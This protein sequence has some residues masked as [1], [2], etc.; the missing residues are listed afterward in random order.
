TDQCG[1]SL[2]ECHITPQF[3][4]LGSRF[5]VFGLG[6]SYQLVFIARGSRPSPLRAL[7]LRSPDIVCHQWTLRLR[8]RQRLHRSAR[9]PHDSTE[10][11]PEFR[12]QFQ[13]RCSGPDALTCT[14]ISQ[15][16]HHVSGAST[17]EDARRSVEF[18]SGCPT[19][20]PPHFGGRKQAQSSKLA[21]PYFPFVGFSAL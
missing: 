13:S 20:V 16:P 18:E 10:W 8:S 4:F 12:S 2:K 9:Q 5:S 6:N 15:M 21:A 3:S 1:D 14:V 11:R 17:G 7:S 19:L